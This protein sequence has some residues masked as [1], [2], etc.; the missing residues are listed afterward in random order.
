MEQLENIINDKEEKPL[1]ISLKKLFLDPNNYRFI[2]NE[3]WVEVADDKIADDNVQRRT[4]SFI[5]GKNNVEIDDLLRSLK[6]NGYLP[7]DQIQVKELENGKGYVVKEGNR[8]ITALKEL[9]EEHIKSNDLGVFN[10]DIFEKIPVIVSRGVDES[11]FK[12]LMGLKHIS[13]NKKW[14]A[15]NQAKMLKSLSDSGMTEYE[16]KDA[17]G[18]TTVSL[19]RYLRTLAF[20]E[21]YQ[22]SD[23]GDQFQNDKFNI[24]SEAI[25]QPALMA[26][27]GWDDNIYKCTND[28]NKQR[29]F[30]WISKEDENENEVG[31]T[32][33][34]IIT[35]G[36]DLRELTKLINNAE[37][38]D[39]MESTRSITTAFINGD[40]QK[41]E[42][43]EDT[44]KNLER[45]I[46]ST[47]SILNYTNENHK[48][49]LFQ[50]KKSFDKLFLDDKRTNIP[51]TNGYKK[52]LVEF[53]N[54]QFTSL[55]IKNYK[56]FRLLTIENIGRINIIAGG[57]NSG[58]SSLLEAIYILASQNDFQ[59]IMETQRRRSK[60][61]DILPAVWFANEFPKV[62]EIEGF[63]DN[64]LAKS[65]IGDCFDTDEFDKSD[66]FTSFQI[67]SNFAS[68]NNYSMMR[69]FYKKTPELIYKQLAI[70]C[71]IRYTSPFSVQ[72]SEDLVYAHKISI[73][74]GVYRKI[75]KFLSENI[76]KG[77]KNIE[78]VID[79]ETNTPRF[80]VEHEDFDKPV[81]LTQFGDGLQRMFHI[82]LQFAAAQNGVMLIDEI[83]NAIHH[84]W[85][86]KFVNFI[87]AL[88]Q[89]FNVQLFVTSHSKECI[90]AFL[91]DEETRIISSCYRLVKKGD[92]ITC[93]YASGSE[94]KKFIDTLNTDL[95]G[96]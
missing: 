63:F 80:R 94:F 93:T 74:N 82:S 83:E 84:S 15:V 7:V 11:H 91:T 38:L 58:K 3:K 62:A 42:Q 13:G 67:Y 89:E 12:I 72:S 37:A 48:D 5:A 40:F 86:V 25:K 23:Y 24:F 70:L 33:E 85:F 22:Q 2:D 50:L 88:I 31:I 16:I 59:S 6:K 52:I 53:E 65:K 69:V 36:T 18:I 81:D 46:N 32:L 26:W 17:L 56:A 51:T 90:E 96:K 30:S 60:F 19:R 49:K 64:K 77:I 28:T 54:K 87:R 9:Q 35:K 61:N 47:F 76:D 41:E 73:D 92:E 34:P 45:S 4:R 55:N 27:L 95:R 39:K 29:F 20:V 71:N 68:T 21:A 44:L 79:E 66:Y 43:L 1:K 57:N 8:R 14:P 78:L 10:T 75:I